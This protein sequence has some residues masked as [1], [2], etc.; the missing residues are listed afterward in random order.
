MTAGY[1][2]ETMQR[3]TCTHDAQD[4]TDSARNVPAISW[5]ASRRYD[6]SPNFRME[7]NAGPP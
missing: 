2:K 5:N 6:R 1:A 4:W 7:A 3:H